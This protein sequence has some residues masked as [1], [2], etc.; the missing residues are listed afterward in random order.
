V[1]NYDAYDFQSCLYLADVVQR[2]ELQELRQNV[3]SGT[4]ETSKLLLAAVEVQRHLG[5]TENR[6]KMTTTAIQATKA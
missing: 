5:D 4:E 1:A 6:K 3:Q 2:G